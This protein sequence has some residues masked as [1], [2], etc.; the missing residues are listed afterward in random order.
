MVKGFCVSNILLRTCSNGSINICIRKKQLQQPLCEAAN[1]IKNIKNRQS[2]KRCLITH[3]YLAFY[4]MATDLWGLSKFSLATT[5]DLKII[6][7][8][9]SLCAICLSNLFQWDIDPCHLLRII[10]FASPQTISSTKTAFEAL[11]LLK[12]FDDF[13]KSVQRC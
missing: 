7:L 6:W 5:S 13:F 3:S 2:V 12:V 11:R 1:E 4:K 8:S 9:S 10:D